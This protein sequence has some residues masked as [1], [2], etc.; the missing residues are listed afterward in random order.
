MNCEELRSD[1]WLYAIGAMGDPEAGEMRAHLARGCENC[2]EGLRQ[3]HALAY[4]MGAVL[5]GPELPREL[6][7]RVLAISG[8]ISEENS[9]WPA[10]GI[11]DSGARNARPASRRPPFWARPIAAWQG[12]ALAMGCVILALAPGVL[13]YRALS[14]SRAAQAAAGALLAREQRNAASLREQVASLEGDAALRAVPIF[15]LELERGAGTPEEAL[16]QLSIPRGAA[17]IVLALPTDLVRQ[18]SAAELRNAAEETIWTV[19]PLP[20]G[21][22]DSTG[23]TIAARLVPP[24]RYAVVLRAGERTVARLLFQ[25]ALH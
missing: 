8:A 2:T 23:L 11:G 6:R 5:N 22:S 20:A 9:P 19:S 3:A 12:F 21:D 13:W 16:K 14:Q 4:S 15:S 18:A 24:G 7:G 10:A 1:Y 17:S 25:V